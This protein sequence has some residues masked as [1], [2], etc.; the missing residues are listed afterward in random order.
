MK[1]K[2]GGELVIL[3]SELKAES[4]YLF[5]GLYSNRLVQRTNLSF[6]YDPPFEI[7]T[8]ITLHFVVSAKYLARYSSSLIPFAAKTDKSDCSIGAWNQNF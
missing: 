3:Y 2:R 5:L 7:K 1:K 4:S 6:I 8:S